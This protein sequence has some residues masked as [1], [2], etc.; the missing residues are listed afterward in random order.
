MV[1]PLAHPGDD[2]LAVQHIRTLYPDRHARR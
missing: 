1:G 2:L